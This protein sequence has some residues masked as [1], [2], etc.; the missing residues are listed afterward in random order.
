MRRPPRA[1]SHTFGPFQ[2]PKPTPLS[3]PPRSPGQ[4]VTGMPTRV[5]EFWSAERAPASPQAPG[6]RG[7]HVCA[8]TVYKRKM[9]SRS[10]KMVARQRASG[11]WPSSRSLVAAITSSSGIR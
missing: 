2:P 9:S 3:K 11:L 4:I 10:S 6:N 7:P 5:I 8:G 1:R